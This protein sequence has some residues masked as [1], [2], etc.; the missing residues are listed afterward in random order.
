M[1]IRISLMSMALML[2]CYEWEPW[3]A[4][5]V[6]FLSPFEG[7]QGDVKH[8]VHKII[9]SHI[10]SN[11]KLSRKKHKIYHFNREYRFL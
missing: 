5:S 8:I 10:I 2:L 6:G 7:G 9:H 4:A 1:S 3:T 11:Y